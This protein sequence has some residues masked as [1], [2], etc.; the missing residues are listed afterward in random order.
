[1]IKQC[2]VRRFAHLPDSL[3]ASRKQRVLLSA[4]GI[5]LLWSVSYPEA[6]ALAQARS[7]ALCLRPVDS[8]YDIGNATASGWQA[9]PEG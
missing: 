7:F 8:H 6:L 5:E 1:L 9:M 3:Q 4:L 2:L